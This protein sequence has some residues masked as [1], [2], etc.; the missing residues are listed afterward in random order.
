[1]P[2]ASASASSV[3]MIEREAE[4]S[5]SG[6]NVEMI[7]HRDRDRRDDRRAQRCRGTGARRARRG[8]APSTRCSSDVVLRPRCVICSGVVA[9]DVE[10]SSRAAGS[11]CGAAATRRLDRRRRPATVFVPDC[12]R[13]DS[14]IAETGRC[15]TAAVS[16][17]FSTV[18]ARSRRRARGPGDRRPGGRRCH[19]SALAFDARDPRCAAWCHGGAH[20]PSR[21]TRHR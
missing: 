9:H 13:T 4:R 2:T 11:G 18:L 8:A 6:E 17:S 16:A 19:R 3:I 15:A 12:L 21:A 14:A 20:A 1:M 7:G 5:S 10:P